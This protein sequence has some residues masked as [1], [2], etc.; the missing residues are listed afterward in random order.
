M[1]SFVATASASARTMFVHTHSSRTKILLFL[2]VIHVNAAKSFTRLTKGQFYNQSKT[3]NTDYVVVQI[4]MI[5]ILIPVDDG[6]I[7][8]KEND[9]EKLM[10]KT[11]NEDLLLILFLGVISK[12]MLG[13]LFVYRCV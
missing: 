7:Q 12:V 4:S 3:G 5:Y 13:D 8:E 1:P 9:Q 10:E 6:S 2:I 11:L